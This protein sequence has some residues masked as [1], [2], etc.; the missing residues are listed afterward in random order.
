MLKLRKKPC[1]INEEIRMRKKWTIRRFK[2]EEEWKANRPYNVSHF[3]HNVLV[4][5]G[6]NELLTLICSSSGTEFDNS[7]AYIGTG[8]SPTAEGPTDTDLIGTNLF[9]VMDGSFPTYGTSQLAV[10]RGTFGSAQAN[11]AWEEFG[12]ANG[13][14]PGGAD[15]L[16]N[17]KTSSEGTKTAGQ[18]WELSLQ[19]TI[20]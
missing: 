10:W 2:N 17:R 4:N 11:Q 18:V 19:I 15:I 8:T 3:Y 13:V 9:I 14:D 6:I 7:N 16:L 5:A 1:L 20:S 12:V